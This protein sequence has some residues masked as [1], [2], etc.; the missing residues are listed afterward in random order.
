MQRCSKKTAPRQ[1]DS[2]LVGFDLLLAF[3][4]ES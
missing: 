3:D 4:H 1:P 2:S